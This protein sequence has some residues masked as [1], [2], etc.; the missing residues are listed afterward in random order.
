MPTCLFCER[1]MFIAWQKPSRNSRT[2]QHS[3]KTQ[4]VCPHC[5]FWQR[6]EIPR[7]IAASL[8]GGEAYLPAAL[9]EEGYPRL[10]VPSATTA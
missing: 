2:G 9:D 6:L 10:T 5:D 4:Y 7:R 3:I 8:A 1:R